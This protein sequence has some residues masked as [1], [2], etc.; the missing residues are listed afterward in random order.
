M[1]MHFRIPT[2]QTHQ[3]EQPITGVHDIMTQPP[4]YRGINDMYAQEAAKATAAEEEQRRLETTDDR[5]VAH[6]MGPAITGNGEEYRPP[7]TP[8]AGWTRDERGR[9]VPLESAPHVGAFPLPGP[10]RHANG[11][12]SRPCCGLVR[13]WCPPARTT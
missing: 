9:R 13:A 2:E 7:V 12:P 5:A 3:C 1:L 8:F 6:P 4:P 10:A 11:L